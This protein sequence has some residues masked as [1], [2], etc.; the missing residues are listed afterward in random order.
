MN[1][2]HNMRVE[3]DSMG[4]LKV[5]VEAYYGAQTMRAILN[6]PISQKKAWR[7]SPRSNHQRRMEDG[8]FF[9][10]EVASS[11]AGRLFLP[12]ALSSIIIS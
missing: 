10:A 2:E 9:R 1:S 3:N 5:P 6:F 7:E 12:R 4:E 11:T 8:G